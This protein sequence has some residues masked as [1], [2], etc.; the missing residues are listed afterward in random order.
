MGLEAAALGAAA[1]AGLAVPAVLLVDDG[2]RLG[3]AGMVMARVDGETLAPRILRDPSLAGAR[4]VLTRQLAAFLAGLH[5]LKP[6]AVPGLAEPDPFG[7]L[8]E[9]LADVDDHSP[10]FELARRWLERH[11]PASGERAVVH[12]DLRLGNVIVGED[13]LRAVL[14][15]E[16]VHIGDPLE[17]LA[18]LCVKAWRFGARP[19]VAGVGTIDEL[20]DA[21]EEAGGQPVDRD[22][23]RWWLIQRPSSGASSAC[24]R[25]PCT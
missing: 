16:L 25:R 12:G 5:G 19:E 11:R 15:W 14:D 1:E 22:A 24:G 10:T 4:A 21:Y 3:T 13:G 18:W 2:R 8:D 7:F 23:F 6:G 17:D 9:L 20:V